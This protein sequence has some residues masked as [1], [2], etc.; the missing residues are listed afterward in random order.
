MTFTLFQITQI[1]A[2]LFLFK[3]KVGSS[4]YLGR[5]KY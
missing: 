3:F 2:P 4:S 5:K 1:W